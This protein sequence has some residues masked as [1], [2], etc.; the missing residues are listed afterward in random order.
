VKGA[1][2]TGANPVLALLLSG[3][4]G[5]GMAW[6]GL[7]LPWIV[8][9]MAAMAAANLSGAE[10]RPPPGGRQLGQIVIGTVLGLYFTPAV[11]RE[12]ATVWHV[13]VAAALLAL[14]LA[15]W[16]GWLLSRISGTDRT[17]TFF[18]S[19]PGGAA[20]M[21]VL[22]ERFGARADRVALAQSL[23]LLAVVIVVPYA[24]TLSGAHGLETGLPAPVPL[25]YTRLGLLLAIAAACGALLAL[26]RIANPFMLGPLFAVTALTAGE[27]Q[28]SSIPG[29]L[30]NLGQMLLGCALGARFERRAFAALPRYVVAV[31]ASIAAAITLAALAGA[32]LAAFSGLAVPSVVLATAPGG[33]AEMCITAQVLQLGVP[34]VTAAHVTR[35]IVL[36][37]ATGPI[38]RLARRFAARRGGC[39]RRRSGGRPARFPRRPGQR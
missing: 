1:R 22:G 18:A 26:A 39:C 3:A 28:F 31:L 29:W 20:E 36:V 35:V 6:L 8:G 34:L 37:T 5:A 2:D 30:S 24:L 10:L 17:T 23:R 4:G 16:S 21:V 25:A 19:V 9:P 7:P 32:A 27:V 15:W 12:L 11:A 33:I 13:L 38:F 14:V